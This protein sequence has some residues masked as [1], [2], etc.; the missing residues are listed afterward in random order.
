ML[1]IKIMV[2]SVRYEVNIHNVYTQ[3]RLGPLSVKTLIRHL[4]LIH[5]FP[6]KSVCKCSVFLSY[7]SSRRRAPNTVERVEHVLAS[8]MIREYLISNGIFELH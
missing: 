5:L 6:D 4:S 8:R 7:P 2:F 3:K 1:T